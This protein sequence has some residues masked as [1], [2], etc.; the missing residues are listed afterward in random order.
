MKKYI[1]TI[2]LFFVTT[3]SA[4]AQESM[5]LYNMQSIPQSNYLNPANMPLSKVNIGLPGIS[6]NYFSV[7]NNGFRYS[8]MVK[9]RDDDSLYFDVED[10]LS[11]LKKNNDLNVNSQIDLFSLGIKVKKHYFSLNLT[12]KLNFRFRYPKD[13]FNFVVLGNGAFLDQTLNFNFG[14]EA[15]HYRELGLNYS[16]QV[17]DKLSVGGRLKVLYGYENVHTKQ[18]DITLYTDPSYFDITA[19]SN[20]NIQ[21]SGIDTSSFSDLEVKNYLQKKK[22]RGAAIDL[23]ANYKLNDKL[24]FS[25]SLLD[26]GAINWKTDNVNYV[27][28]NANASFTFTGVDFNTFINDTINWETAGE[29]LTDSIVGTFQIESKRG[30]AYKTWLPMQ[31]YLN[32]NYHL[33]VKNKVS[34]TLYNQFY[35]KAPHPAASIAFTTRAG[36]WASA[37]V[38]YTA[39]HRSFNNIG[40]GFSLNLGPVQLYTVADNVFA[41]IKPQ[42]TKNFNVRMALN[43]TFGR[44]HIDRDRD[45]VPDKKDDCPDVKG[46]VQFNG[47]P[48]GDGDGVIDLKDNCPDIAGL[49][50]FSGCPDRDGDKVID[51]QDVCPD[52]AGDKDLNGCPDKD[53]DKIIDEKD[54]C[55][56]V[57]GIKEFEGCPDKDG[58]KIIDSDDECPELAG[59]A[60]FKG[61]PDTD[62][63]GIK[64]SEDICP[65]RPGTLEKRGCPIDR[66]LILDETGKVIAIAVK[67][68]EGFFVFEKLPDV[69]SFIYK[70][71]GTDTDFNNMKIKFT[72]GGEA[73]LE[74]NANGTFSFKKLSQDYNTLT[75]LPEEDATVLLKKEEEEIIKKAF[76]NLE[77]NTGKAIINPN[78]LPSLTDLAGLLKSKP[79]WRIRISGHTD[80]VGNAKANLTLSKGRAEAVK[81][82]LVSKGV[83]VNAVLV[84]YYGGTEPIADNATEEGRQK[85][86]RVEMKIID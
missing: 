63:D 35:D 21:T 20:I 56:D 14:V 41:L 77:F 85:N 15:M 66:L 52:V 67:N 71:E 33:N 22:N 25:A 80:N 74:K 84:N 78:S 37:S 32:A 73:K 86:R 47:C 12:E 43:L 45:G 36:R 34:A 39:A 57:A 58:D 19:S 29:K 59:I 31:M 53:G 72:E 17:N 11:K 51:S 61:C 8:D 24:S 70:L 42:H 60:Q 82:Y 65:D 83:N 75:Q 48:D 81:K 23:G 46:L 1:H 64:D 9:K 44:D 27:N 62:G 40:F 79:D 30:V 55:P 50:E 54:K 16:Q 4:F 13:F 2:I 49:A 7:N 5:T 10:W 18:S 76:D 68:E 28:K 26:V 69:A 3:F 6:S 38:S